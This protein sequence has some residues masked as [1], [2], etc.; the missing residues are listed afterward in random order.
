MLDRDEDMVMTG[1][2]H[3]FLFKYRITCTNDG[4]IT[5]AYVKIYQNAG[6]SA[7]LSISVSF[8]SN[9]CLINRNKIYRLP[10]YIFRFL[11]VPCFTS[12]MSIKYQ[13]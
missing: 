11:N 9:I 12:I 13:M 10:N 7:D 2:R 3:P 5:G 8:F 4:K 6:Y 1:T